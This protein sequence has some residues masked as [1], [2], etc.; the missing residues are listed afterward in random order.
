MQETFDVR[1]YGDV[2]VMVSDVNKELGLKAKT[3]DLGHE[4][5]EVSGQGLT[6]FNIT[7]DG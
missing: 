3:K 4:A 2:F 1:Y 6:S 5:L 7:D